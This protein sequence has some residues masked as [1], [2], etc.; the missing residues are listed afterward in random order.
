[1]LEKLPQKLKRSTP[2]K[3]LLKKI[4]ELKDLLV[5]LPDENI[6]H[7]IRKVL[8]DILYNWKFIKSLKKQAASLLFL[9]KKIY[10]RSLK[11]LATLHR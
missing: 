7:S 9:I 8:K 4:I 3:F 10:D 1:M 11:H 2:K 5:K 6:L